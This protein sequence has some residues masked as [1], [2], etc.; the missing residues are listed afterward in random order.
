M[1]FPFT[2]FVSNLWIKRRDVTEYEVV[3]HN[4]FMGGQIQRC[5][6][7]LN[8]DVNIS[9]YLE[10]CRPVGHRGAA[11]ALLSDS[12]REQPRSVR[13]PKKKTKVTGIE[14]RGI[15]LNLEEIKV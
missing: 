7:S 13:V 8:L 2:H 4:S 14:F 15:E 12:T 6:A 1:L 9:L 11:V 5:I 3:V 10:Y